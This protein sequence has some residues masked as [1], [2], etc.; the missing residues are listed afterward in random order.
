MLKL[1]TEEIKQL[2]TWEEADLWLK[3]HGWGP[4]LVDEQKVL[5]NN[6]KKS[7]ADSAE[8]IFDTVTGSIVIV[9]PVA[10]EPI[11]EKP[12]APVKAGK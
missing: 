7:G 9:A 8:L 11:A 5:W 12:A 1:L 10:V 3:T 6:Y 2:T 4:G